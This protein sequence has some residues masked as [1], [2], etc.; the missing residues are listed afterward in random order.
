[1][2]IKVRIEIGDRVVEVTAST[3]EEALKAFNLASRGKFA[4]VESPRDPL[5]LK[6]RV[7]KFG[8][9]TQLVDAFGV[10]LKNKIH[11]IKQLR[12][13]TGLGLADAKF[14]IEAGEFKADSVGQA[15]KLRAALTGHVVFVG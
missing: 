5:L 2:D 3:R 15:E 14:A 11:A 12:E 1:M 4:E 13:V 8:D 10:E 9:Y 6:W 7:A